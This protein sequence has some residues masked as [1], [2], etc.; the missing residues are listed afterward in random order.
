MHVLIQILVAG[1][2][3]EAVVTDDPSVLSVLDIKKISFQYTGRKKEE[4]LSLSVP[5][6]TSKLVVA[7]AKSPISFT[8]GFWENSPQ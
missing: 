1:L 7:G 2:R 5:L 8:K 3:H 4:K 6:E